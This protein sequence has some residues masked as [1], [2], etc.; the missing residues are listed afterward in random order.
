[1]SW[2]DLR[3]G[4]LVIA[5]A[6]GFGLMP[7][8]AQYAYDEG[9]GVPTLLFLRFSIAAA[10]LLG[11]LAVTRT[12]LWPGW[13]AL[14]RLALLGGVLYAAQSTLYF[15]AVRYISPTLAVLLLYLY[16]ALV[17]LLVAVIERTPPPMTRVASIALALTGLV[18]VLGAPTGKVR[19]AGVLLALGAALT[20]AVYIVAGDRFSTVLPPFTTAAYIIAFAAVSFAVTGLARGAIDLTISPRGWAAVLGVAVIS[21]IVA[22][23]CFFAGLAAVGPA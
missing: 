11:Y 9:M 23:G 16:P 2:T 13:R 5:A 22:I 15:T 4:L 17:A 19:V 21:T 12:L 20:Y 7:I 10:A 14:A 18:I 6:A 3:G 8:F 1:M